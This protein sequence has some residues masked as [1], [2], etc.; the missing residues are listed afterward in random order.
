MP[1]AGRSAARHHLGPRT[2]RHRRQAA[3]PPPRGGQ[4]DQRGAGRGGEDGMTS[5]AAASGMLSPASLRALP[6]GPDL[7]TLLNAPRSR[8]VM[9]DGPRDPNSGVTLPVTAPGST[10]PHPPLK[11]PTTAP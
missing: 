7:R 11:A 5:Q 8:A 10:R 6:G 2:A 3:A 4:L 1:L 9:L